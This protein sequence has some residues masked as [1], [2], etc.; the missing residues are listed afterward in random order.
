MKLF[1]PKMAGKNIRLTYEMSSYDILDEGN[2]I[3]TEVRSASALSGEATTSVGT[4]A[5]VLSSLIS[6]GVN[7]RIEKI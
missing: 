6:K 5:A 3:D 4:L 7:V 2:N 1:G